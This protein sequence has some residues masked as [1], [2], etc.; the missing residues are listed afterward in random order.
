MR[1]PTLSGI[2]SS[3]GYPPALEASGAV[4]SVSVRRRLAGGGLDTR[5]EVRGSDELADL[6]LTFNVTAATLESNIAELQR[7]EAHARRFVADVSHELRTPLAGLTAVTD[8][9]EEELSDAGGDTGMAVRLVGTQT[10]RL[11]QLVENLIEISRF[12]AGQ[13]VLRLE[14]GVDMGAL[15]RTTLASRGW[16]DR[17]DAQLPTGVL[18][19]VDVFRVEVIVANVVGNALKH[20]AP[21]VTVALVDVPEPDG[22]G[23]VTVTVTD[24]GPGVPPHVRPYLFE[25][26]FK[27]DAAR[28][29]SEGSGLGLAIAL[30]NA[31]L[32][33][34]S[35][36]SA[37]PTWWGRFVRAAP[38]PGSGGAPMRRALLWRLVAAVLITSLLP[39]CGIQSTGVG[40]GGAAAGGVHVYYVLDGKLHPSFEQAPLVKPRL[41]SGSCSSAPIEPIERP[42]SPPRFRL[43]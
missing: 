15:I 25:R 27:A 30:Q 13:A 26:F 18:A 34:G 7:M 33:G 23:A 41:L 1:L 20:G 42:E 32:H 37:R 24:R 40:D 39:A 6:A 43:V 17:V 36:R 8:T 11:A 19:E 10:R 3:P 12:D 16:T 22:T 28:T 21:P 31:R 38:T 35:N 9:L 29:R 2:S 5:I 14:D 4:S